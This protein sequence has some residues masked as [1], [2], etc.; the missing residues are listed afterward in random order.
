MIR[1]FWSHEEKA[2]EVSTACDG[3]GERSLGWEDSWLNH[4]SVVWG[5]GALIVRIGFW[6]LGPIILELQY[7]NHQNSFFNYLGPFFRGMQAMSVDLRL[8]LAL[9]LGCGLASWIV[10]Q[11][12]HSTEH[13]E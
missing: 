4:R 8:H 1:H 9:T 12:Q 5:L 7:G 6:A 3:Q 13:H 2:Q 11:W 10:W